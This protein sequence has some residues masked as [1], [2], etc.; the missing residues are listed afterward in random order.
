MSP[1]HV[2]I[3]QEEDR[4]RAGIIAIIAI[5]TLI[6]FG[7]GIL[8]AILIVF[9][10][11]KDIRAEPAPI[12]SL[13]GQPVIGIVEQPMFERDRRLAD[14]LAA[15][16]ERLSTYGFVDRERG[17]IHIPIEEAMKRVAAGERP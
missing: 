6:V 17:R 12:P 9:S 10:V 3:Y 5:V 7:I 15:Q 1:R 11:S 8:W 14:M 16:R 2:V 4:V 13:I